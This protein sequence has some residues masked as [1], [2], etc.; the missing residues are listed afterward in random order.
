MKNNRIFLYG[1][2]PVLLFTTCKPSV[3]KEEI[4]REIFETE[5]AFERMA[6]EKSIAEAFYYYADENAV[7]IREHDTL[8]TGKENIKAY[9]EAR[10]L[11]NATVKWTPDFVEVSESGDLGYTYGQYLWTI[12]S[13]EDT[14]EFKGVFHT[15]W[16]KQEDGSWK[17]VWD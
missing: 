3:T 11:K 17:Y 7:I 12:L 13:P 9:Y 15:V 8:I 10:E 16:K 14:S 4:T 2:I 1:V 6:E 5:K